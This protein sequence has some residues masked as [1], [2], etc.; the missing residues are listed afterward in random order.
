MNE[1]NAVVDAP[2]L[3]RAVFVEACDSG[4]D[5]QT[6][7]RHL[8]WHEGQ[9]HEELQVFSSLRDALAYAQEACA[10]PNGPPLPKT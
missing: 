4:W 6:I 7:V 8:V 9:L 1:A 3:E 5:P 2:S 10:S